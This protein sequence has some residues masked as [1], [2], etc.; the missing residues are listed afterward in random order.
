MLR[1]KH[2]KVEERSRTTRVMMPFCSSEKLGDI[3]CIAEAPVSVTFGSFQPARRDLPVL[4]CPKG[5][6][7]KTR[8]GYST[9]LELG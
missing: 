9:W 2:R 6:G 1:A 5:P 8:K 7:T 4:T 3:H